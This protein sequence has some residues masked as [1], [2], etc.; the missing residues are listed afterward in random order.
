ML[1]YWWVLVPPSPAGTALAGCSLMQCCQPCCLSPYLAVTQTP[2]VCVIFVFVFLHSADHLLLY[3]AFPLW[4]SFLLCNVIPI[5]PTPLCFLV[6]TSL[7]HFLLAG[8]MVFKLSEKSYF[9]RTVFLNALQ[10]HF[11]RWNTCLF[12]FSYSGGHLNTL[13]Q[14][15]C[16]FYVTYFSAM[17]FFLLLCFLVCR[18]ILCMRLSFIQVYF[19]SC[20]PA[21]RARYGSNDCSSSWLCRMIFCPALRE[22]VLHFLLVPFVTGPTAGLLWS[23]SAGL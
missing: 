12:F 10:H 4:L 5:F 17:K 15:Y 7:F 20:L 6:T 14:L 19:K 22:N 23:G 21:L 18:P 9:M 1:W 11:C 13:I 3:F 16:R 8:W 2:S